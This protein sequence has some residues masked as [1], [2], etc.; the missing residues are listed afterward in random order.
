MSLRTGC[1]EKS[2]H[3]AGDHEIIEH[4]FCE[5][6]ELRIL[7]GLR[8]AAGAD[9]TAYRVPACRHACPTSGTFRSGQDRNRRTLVY[10]ALATLSGQPA[11]AFPVGLSKSGMPM[12]CKPSD[13]TWRTSPQSAS[14]H[15]RRPRWVGSCHQ[16]GSTQTDTIEL[17]DETDAPVTVWTTELARVLQK[18]SAVQSCPSA[19]SLNRWLVERRA[20]V[21]D[22]RFGRSAQF[23]ST[24]HGLRERGLS[25]AAAS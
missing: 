21:A 15:L 24:P 8:C 4:V 20:S 14:R 1:W 19:P 3:R 7:P 2:P 10:P 11:T 9:N 13:R 17:S 16:R 23:V 22:P 18:V 25:H 12:G 5:C 6:A